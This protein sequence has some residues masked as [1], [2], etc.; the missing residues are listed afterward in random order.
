MNKLMLGRTLIDD[1]AV[2]LSPAVL[3][4]HVVILGASGS[5]KTYLSKVVVEEAIRLGVPVIA[6]DS[7]GDIASMELSNEPSAEMTDIFNEYWDK[8][9]IKFWTPG[10]EWGIPVSLQPNLNLSVYERRE[11]RI[12]AVHGMGVEVAAL[13][14]SYSEAD[15]AGLAKIINYAD[16]NQLVISTI[17]DICDFLRDPP[18]PLIDELN[19]IFDSKDRSRVLKALLI[20]KNGPRQLLLE[21]G[22]PI[23]IDAL[24]GYETGGSYDN[25]K[26]RISIVSLNAL[27]NLE[28]KQLF[29][30]A[31]ARSMYAWMIQD[32]RDYPMAMVY[33]DEAAPYLPPVRKPMCKEPLMLL[34]RQARKYGV[35]ML[36]ATQSPGDLD[37][38]GM[39][40][41][42]TKLLGRI[43]T[44]Q[45][46]WKI[47]PLLENDPHD[48][49]DMLPELQ[50]GEFVAV[51]PDMFKVPV[52]FKSRSLSSKHVTLTLEQAS[53]FVSDEDR[54]LLS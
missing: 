38:T 21:L 2:E 7:Q 43:S 1:S 40:Q 52:I 36:I 19:G 54:N 15:A 44:Q 3:L 50:Q 29:L 45:E 34:L 16:V 8:V 30:A 26:V 11:D 20:K 17:D 22:Q 10:S 28:D 33:I 13:A 14:G 48:S 42:G 51:C 41:V 18:Q 47:Q 37:F 27:S 49:L 24:L 12:R 32:P 25:G 4:K 35:S 23:N 39:A 31:F 6:I 53:K 46:A 9:D 5:G